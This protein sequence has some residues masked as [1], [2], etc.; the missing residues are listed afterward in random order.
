[1]KDNLPIKPDVIIVD[2]TT[3]TNVRLLPTM[4]LRHNDGQPAIAII[5]QKLEDIFDNKSD[6]SIDSIE[7]IDA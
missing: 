4:L 5:N 3:N 6:K 7:S 2:R 1:M